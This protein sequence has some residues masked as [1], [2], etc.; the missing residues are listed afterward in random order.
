MLPDPCCTSNLEQILSR[1]ETFLI[2]VLSSHIDSK[3]YIPHEIRIAVLSKNTSFC[4]NC[5]LYR[6]FTGKENLCLNEENIRLY[7]KN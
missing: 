7:Q 2:S 4:N 5:H 1:Q 6:N 3:N